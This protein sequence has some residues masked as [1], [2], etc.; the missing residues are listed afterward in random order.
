ME[1]RTDVN[2]NLIRDLAEELLGILLLEYHNKNH[3][4]WGSNSKHLSEIE[5]E[6]VQNIL[7]ICKGANND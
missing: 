2:V 6:L 5:I 4:Q 3:L 1:T 7:D